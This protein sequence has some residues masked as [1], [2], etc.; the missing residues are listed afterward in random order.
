VALDDDAQVDPATLP[1]NVELMRE[2]DAHIAEA[3]AK[4]E[5]QRALEARLSGA[6][7]D[8]VSRI[9]ERVVARAASYAQEEDLRGGIADELRA[10]GE[11]V[12]TEARLR[13]P[14][15]TT[16]LG[17]F[18]LAI[19]VENSLVLGETKW[20]DGNLYECMWDLFKLGSAR[21]LDR[22]EAT[23][24]VYGA[25][26]KHW[27]RAEGCARLFEDREVL[28]RNLICALP[29]EWQI[30][31]DGSTAKPHVIPMLLRLQLLTATTC[32]V[33]GKQWEIRAVG[34][35]A[36]GGDYPLTKGW[37]KEGRP[38]APK[39]YTW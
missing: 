18:D 27:Q 23:I 30:N 15:W 16:N 21:S 13:L 6:I 2:I 22:V 10:R 39:P 32:E 31:L 24:A 34:V 26:V 14:G 28:T 17:G 3:D 19:V 8:A 35:T 20:A 29:R 33:F 11:L 4:R 5:Q 36:G 37:P 12:L 7:P 1:E 38:E 9:E 25:P